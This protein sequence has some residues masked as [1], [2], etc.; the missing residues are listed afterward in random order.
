VFDRTAIYLTFGNAIVYRLTPFV[1]YY[2]T[3]Y[4][5]NIYLKSKTLNNK[6]PELFCKKKTKKTNTD[7]IVFC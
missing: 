7:A 1:H 3:N 6:K 2:S 4:I 5:K